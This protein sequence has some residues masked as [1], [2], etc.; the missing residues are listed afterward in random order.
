MESSDRIITLLGILTEPEAEESGLV[1]PGHVYE[2]HQQKKHEA[3]RE[4]ARLQ[5][6]PA[7]WQMFASLNRELP[8]GT[9]DQVLSLAG[10]F[11][12]ILLPVFQH[13]RIEE[14][15]RT[16]HQKFLREAGAVDPFLEGANLTRDAF[17]LRGE[18]ERDTWA[19]GVNLERR[20]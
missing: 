10:V 20:Y 9:R 15:G 17:S 16:N 4:L 3:L 7:I 5:S 11:A 6:N 1:L 2:R 14:A 18:V 8:D 12:V 19:D 13:S